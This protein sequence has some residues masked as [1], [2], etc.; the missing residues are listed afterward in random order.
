MVR[1]QA[2][3]KSCD[4]VQ[5]VNA[6]FSKPIIHEDK[7]SSG[8]SGLP[9]RMMESGHGRFFRESPDVTR[10]LPGICRLG[11]HDLSNG[12]ASSLSEI[13]GYVATVERCGGSRSGKRRVVT[14]LMD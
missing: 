2:D 11:L 12:G 1:G 14:L 3:A 6:G 4:P 10:V 5:C 13:I 9:D 8:A 7:M